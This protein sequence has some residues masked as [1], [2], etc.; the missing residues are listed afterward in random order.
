VLSEKGE[1]MDGKA[2]TLSWPDKG[3]ALATMT[4]AGE[5]NTLSME[6]LE[7]LEEAL[8]VCRG[9][10]AT[11]MIITGS[12]RA[13]CCGAHLKYFAGDGV[14]PF[15]PF[16]IRDNYLNRIALLFDRIEAVPFPVIAA[17][18]GFA[19]GGGCEMALACDFRIM[20]RDARIGLPEV[21]LGAIPGAGG[22]QKLLRFVG[23]GKALEWILLASHLTSDDADRYGLLYAAVDADRVLPAAMELAGR[24]KKL[25][26]MAIGQSKASIHVSGDVD[27]RSARRFGLEALTSL[28]GTRD[29][30]EGMRAFIEKRPPDFDKE[31]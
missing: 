26:P 5:M 29:W 28:I 22:V 21:K 8:D 9:E 13:F 27:L 3:V 11:A 12:G 1:E 18:N 20:S 25:S 15:S 17:I 24:F 30:E 10:R 16:E 31:G 19:L 6:L 14:K 23:R 2:L 4:R 7:E